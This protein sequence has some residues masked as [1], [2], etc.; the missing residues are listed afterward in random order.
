MKTN[1]SLP[2]RFAAA[3]DALMHG[4]FPVADTDP[5]APELAV[6]VKLRAGAMAGIP[7]PS[8]IAGLRADLRVRIAAPKTAIAPIHYSVIDTPVGPLAVAYRNGRVVY[9]NAVVG[10]EEERGARS[11][12][13]DEIGLGN[14]RRLP[15]PD[16]RL[17]SE[18]AFA[19]SVAQA[20]GA[21]P[22]REDA[23]PAAIARGMR[24]FFAGKRKFTAVDLSWLTPFQR[25]VL[26]KTAEIPRGEVRPYGWVAREIGS[27]GATRAVG[28]ALGHNPI[29]FLIPCHRVVRSDGSLGE[30]SG[31]GPA[32]KERVLAYE[33]A[34]MEHLREVAT[35]GGR[36]LGSRT[37][38]IVCYPSCHQA[39]RI[40][41]ENAVSFASLPSAEASGYRPCRTCRPA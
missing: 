6:A 23:P 40:R 32:V 35:R 15:T 12:E 30:Y 41:P 4:P 2:E 29:P 8:F 18:L 24:D 38:H 17:P 28:T 37:T 36:Y 33:G 20:L 3:T 21:R 19:R 34:P 1:T 31:G 9:C 16:S 27:P 14:L 13:R 10:D 25:R 7:D 22:E 26:E 5:I 11:E 39:Q